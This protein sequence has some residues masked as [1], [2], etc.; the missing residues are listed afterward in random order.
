MKLSIIYKI[1]EKHQTVQSNLQ[2]FH[3]F[4]LLKKEHKNKYNDRF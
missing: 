2:I 4:E 1:Q 3:I